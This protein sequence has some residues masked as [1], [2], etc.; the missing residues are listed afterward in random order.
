MFKLFIEG[1]Q[2]KGYWNRILRRIFG[3]MSDEN[4]VKINFNSAELHRLYSSLNMFRLI[5]SWR[6]KWASRI[7]KMGDRR[8]AFKILAGKPTARRPLGMSKC[9]WEDNIRIYF[10]EIRN[11]IDSAQDRD[12]WRALL[13]AALNLQVSL[14]ME[15]VS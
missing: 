4:G 14:A 7:G 11:L 6:L 8:I 9:S 12:H 10:K 2:T 3:P 15:L 1:K 13:K 5:I